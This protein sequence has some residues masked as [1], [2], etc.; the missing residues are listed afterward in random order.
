M[1]FY[2]LKLPTSSLYF[3]FVLKAGYVMKS[4]EEDSIDSHLYIR[5][6]AKTVS[7]GECS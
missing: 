2:S 3:S 7:L 6:T 1:C 4:H 5:S